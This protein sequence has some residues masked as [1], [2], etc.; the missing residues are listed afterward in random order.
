MLSLYLT[1]FTVKKRN[2][3]LASYHILTEINLGL[4]TCA[5]LI[6]W[7]ILRPLVFEELKDEKMK[8]VNTCCLH[9]LPQIAFLIDF[10]NSN[11]KL[12]A[13]HSPYLFLPFTFLYGAVNYYFTIYVRNDDIYFFLPWTTDTGGA[14]IGLFTCSALFGTVFSVMA[15]VSNKCSKDPIEARY[16]KL[17]TY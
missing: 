6:F 8:L 13:W 11:T 10:M 16:K 12:V 7:T 17:K 4:H 1:N 9:S 3:L 5:C 2:N 14:I 15:F